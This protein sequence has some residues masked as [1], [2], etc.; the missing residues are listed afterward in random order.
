VLTLVS[1]AGS[2][3]RVVAYN[4][5]AG[6]VSAAAAVHLL[7]YFLVIRYTTWFLVIRYTTWFWQGADQTQHG[8]ST[9]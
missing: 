6:R 8:S 7:E 3:A 2:K 5:F 1:D 9:V 4:I